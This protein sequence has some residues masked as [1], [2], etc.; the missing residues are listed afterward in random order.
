[1]EKSPFS[2]FQEAFFNLENKQKEAFSNMFYKVKTLPKKKNGDFS[3]LF[4]KEWRLLHFVFLVTFK[5]GK[6]RMEISP[7]FLEKNGDY[8]ILF[9]K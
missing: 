1:M 7:F 3:I 5:H 9:R 2:F 4:F 6:K 8:S